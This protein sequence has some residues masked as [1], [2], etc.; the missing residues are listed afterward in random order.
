M[1]VKSLE[2]H[3]NA[4]SAFHAVSKRYIN[5]IELQGINGVSTSIG[6]QME[7]DESA[8]KQAAGEAYGGIVW[9]EAYTMRSLWTGDRKHVISLLRQINDINEIS[10]NIGWS[11]SV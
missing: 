8:W 10:R 7:G 1:E 2:D 11:G 6:E 5:S 3:V 9:S 4:F